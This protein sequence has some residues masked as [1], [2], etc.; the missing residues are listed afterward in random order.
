L[1]NGHGLRIG[2]EGF[3]EFG[4][5]VFEKFSVVEAK[6]DRDVSDRL[7]FR[8]VVDSLFPDLPGPRKDELACEATRA[9]WHSATRSYPLRKSALR[10]LR[11]LKA[12]GLRM[13]VVSNHH[14]YESLKAH[15]EESGIDSYFEVVL[16]SEKEGVRKPNAVI[17]ERS[18]RAIGVEKENAIFVGD[19]PRHDIVGARRAGLGTV[20]IDDGEQPEGWASYAGATGQEARPDYVIRDLSELRRILG[21]GGAR[22][23][24]RVERGGR[25]T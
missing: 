19:S 23:S 15:L 18:L 24:R 7:K 14:D 21:L 8:E 11:E 10:T 5:S 12:A 17:F 22:G 20:L 13:G 2:L 4:D 1:L 9:F 6:E 25:L 16:A 3:V